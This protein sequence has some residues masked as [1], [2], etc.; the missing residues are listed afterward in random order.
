MKTTILA[1]KKTKEKYL[2]IA[3]HEYRFILAHKETGELK[4]ESLFD[5]VESYTLHS[6]IG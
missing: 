5:L 3:Q 2:V 1:D 4:V 6:L